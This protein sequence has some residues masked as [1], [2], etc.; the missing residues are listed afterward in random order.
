MYCTVQSIDPFPGSFFLPP[1]WS[2]ALGVWWRLIAR[3][4]ALCVNF[5][6]CYSSTQLANSGTTANARERRVTTPN[7]VVYPFP[8]T[9]PKWS[10]NFP[11]RLQLL[12]GDHNQ[13]N[14]FF[15]GGFPIR[16]PV[17]RMVWFS[18]PN[19]TCLPLFCCVR[20]RGAC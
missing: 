16:F 15:W 13:K 7:T 9:L 19:F 11:G 3:W 14:R 6:S 5:I 18:R 2:H 20:F 17:V 10:G 1:I 12:V 4:K 8:G